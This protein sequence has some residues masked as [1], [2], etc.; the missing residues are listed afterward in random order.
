MIAVC[1][2]ALKNSEKQICQTQQTSPRFPLQAAANLMSRWQSHWPS[3]CAEMNDFSARR[4]VINS[5]KL[6]YKVTNTGD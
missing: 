2:L 5:Y 6:S 1:A 4:A 3:V